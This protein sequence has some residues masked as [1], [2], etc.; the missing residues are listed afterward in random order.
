M[1]DQRLNWFIER[2]G[3]RIFRNVTSCKCQTCKLVFENGLI[4][5]NE[6]HANYLYDM[7]CI[8]T[9]EGSPLKYF[10]TIEEAGKF[11]L[12]LI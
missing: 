11:A 4:I 10:D 12:T 5:G 1:K 3:K 9:H 8:Y 7:E 2:I 6:I